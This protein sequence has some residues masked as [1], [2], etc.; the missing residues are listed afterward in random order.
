MNESD[1]I[2]EAT[3]FDEEGKPIS[4]AEYSTDMP[5]EKWTTEYITKLIEEN[6]YGSRTIIIFLN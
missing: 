6:N 4:T 5:Y 1:Q 2:F 3:E